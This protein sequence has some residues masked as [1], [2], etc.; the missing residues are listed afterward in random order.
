MQ[1]QK[2]KAYC[3]RRT[4]CVEEFPNFELVVEGAGGATPVV[5]EPKPNC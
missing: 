5:G 3:W 2:A 4:D 1:S